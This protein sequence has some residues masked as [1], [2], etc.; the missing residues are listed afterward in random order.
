MR[1]QWNCKLEN[2]SVGRGPRLLLQK[3]V[4]CPSLLQ[5]LGPTT[6][7]YCSPIM[8]VKPRPT[9]NGVGLPVYGAYAP[10]V[11]RKIVWYVG[12]GLYEILKYL[13]LGMRPV[14]H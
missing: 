10:P 6:V 1:K 4:E 14:F 9:C 7:V 8:P 12:L 3:S 2:S 13:C 5:S 11:G